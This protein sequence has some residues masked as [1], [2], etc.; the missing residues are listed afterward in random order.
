LIGKKKKPSL[1]EEQLKTLEWLRGLE[2]NVDDDTRSW[3]AKK[4]TRLRL[5]D[6]YQATLRAKPKSIGAMMQDILKNG[7]AVTT[8]QDAKNAEYAQITKSVKQWDNLEI[9]ERYATID[10]GYGKEEI[11]FNMDH[12]QFKMYLDAKYDTFEGAAM[13]N[14]KAKRRSDE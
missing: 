10:I 1:D 11:P 5:E 6:V 4:Y 12:E 3:W 13:N 14:R 2:L 7:K 9:H 8:S